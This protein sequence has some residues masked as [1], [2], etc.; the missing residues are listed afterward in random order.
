MSAQPADDDHAP[1]TPVPEPARRV[2]GT[3][4]LVAIETTSDQ[5]EPATEAAVAA[6]ADVTAAA[7]TERP[8]IPEHLRRGNLGA[9]V[10]LH[11]KRYWHRARWHGFRV[12]WHG[13][14]M[15][16]YAVRGARRS[17]GHLIRWW[18][19]TDGALMESAAVAVGR[20]AHNDALKYHTEGKRTR[21]KRGRIVACTGIAV[22]GAL[23]A[24][25]AYA[26]WWGWLVLSL[27]VV[28]VLVRVGK[29]AGKP[30]LD[31]AVISA[32]YEKLTPDIIVRA[33]GS[34]SIS[35]IDKVLREGREIAFVTPVVRDGPGYRVAIDLPF[36]VTVPEIVDKREKLASGLRRNLGCVW[37]EPA[38]DEHAG[39]LELYVCDEPLSKAR[40]PAWPLA[41]AGSADLFQPIPFGTDQRGRTVTILLMFAN[42]LIGSIPRQGKTVAVRVIL[43]AAALC[44]L[45]ELRVFELKGTGD[46]EPVSGCCHHY[47]SGADDETIAAALDSLREIAET[48]LI[49]RAKVIRSLPKDKCPDSKVT[50]E[51]ARM[52]SLRL[53]P[54]VFAIDE[55]QE[56]F[57]HPEYGKLFAQ[58]ATA[59]IKRGPALGIMLVLA[60]QKP[61]KDSLPTS[62]TSNVAIRFCLKVMD[63]IANDMVLGTSAYKTGVRATLMTASDK[64]CGY[65]VG[66]ADAAQVVKSF[67][68]DGRQAD[69]IGA[70][71]RVMRQQAG[72]LTGFALGETEV[73]EVRNFAGD[74]LSVFGTDLRLWSAT[75]AERLSVLIPDA[76]ADITAE[77]VASQ[78]RALDVEVKDVREKGRG[79]SA[80]PR[81][82]CTR[83]DVEKSAGV[84]KP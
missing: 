48:E 8:I 18:H 80:G 49:R 7:G 5:I 44:P 64:G 12:P 69:R 21:A 84:V 55:A 2:P 46:L 11:R 23:A 36:G 19:W 50:P 32:A 34:L 28:T 76:Y 14:R 75:I 61:D 77:A 60:T 40:Q 72:T 51:L 26:P 82:G 22:L 68:I 47:G 62:I 1:G 27:A 13:A 9:T 37:P 43:L 56:A 66:A 59:V 33:L 17:A 31:S 52:K 3:T 57:G 25:V 67:Y 45:A 39:R 83:A 70:R 54:I 20:S 53:H 79:A 58:Y 63:Q 35:G 4:E 16:R 42:L 15:A 38:S 30:L 78:L 65:L 24:M 29:P 10:T 81:K 71:A 73:T 6:Y 41:R 74:V